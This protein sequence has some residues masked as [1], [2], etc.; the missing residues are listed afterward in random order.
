M[1]A[2]GGLLERVPL[3]EPHGVEWPAAGVCAE[4]VDRDDPG[5]FQPAGDLCLGQEPGATVRLV[6]VVVEDLLE[7]HL[8]VQL[9][10]DRHEDG[11]QAAAG[12]GPEDAVTL[13][14]RRGSADGVSGGA[15]GVIVAIAIGAEDEADERRVDLRVVEGSEAPPDRRLDPDGGNALPGVIAVPLEVLSGQRLDQAALLGVEVAEGLK[16][17]VQGPGLVADPG[18]EG[19]HELDLVDQADLE[20][21]EAEEEVAVGVGYHRACLRVTL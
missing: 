3:D 14:V 11:A 7:R 4:A 9:L 2:V 19:G 12:V 18:V 16:V 5:V 15:F 17:V 6:G 21:Q 10:V 20:S 1:E 8:A 13:A